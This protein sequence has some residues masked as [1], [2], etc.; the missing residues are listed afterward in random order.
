[1]QLALEEFDK[2]VNPQN[3]KLLILLMDTAGWHKTKKIKGLNNIII[4]PIPAYTPKFKPTECIWSLIRECLA[5][6]SF[7]NLDE[8]ENILAQR[9]LWLIEHPTVTADSIFFE[10]K[11][12]EHFIGSGIQASHLNDDRLGRVLDKLSLPGIKK[13]FTSS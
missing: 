5:N 11:A 2:Q 13:I 12:I 8:L 1:M 7:N 6:K 10:G 9:C 4:Y 3:N